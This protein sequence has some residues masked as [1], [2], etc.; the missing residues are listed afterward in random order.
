MDPVTAA[1]DREYRYRR[2]FP[3]S[4]DEY[5]DEPWDVIEWSL[6]ISELRGDFPWQAKQR[7]DQRGDPGAG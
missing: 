2:L 1:M 4:H 5:L 6:R 7:K 3:I